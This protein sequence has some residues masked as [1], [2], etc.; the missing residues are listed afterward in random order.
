MSADAPA[1]RSKYATALDQRHKAAE[2]LRAQKYGKQFNKTLRSIGP[3]VLSHLEAMPA[4]CVDSAKLS[5]ILPALFVGYTWPAGVIPYPRHHGAF[6]AYLLTRHDLSAADV[7]ELGDGELLNLLIDDI[8]AAIHSRGRKRKELTQ[9]QQ[10]IIEMWRKGVR[11]KEI[12]HALDLK[13]KVVRT[14]IASQRTRENRA[15]QRQGQEQA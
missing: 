3:A 10:R 5:A 14:T 2:R 12:A 1:R 4:D 15:R 8:K 7:A 6:L 9:D 11:S 13:I